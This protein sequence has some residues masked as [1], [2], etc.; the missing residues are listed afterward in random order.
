V[1]EVPA[2]CPEFRLLGPR[3]LANI[4]VRTRAAYFNPEYVN[5]WLL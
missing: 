5:W 3:R 4:E 1:A 2:L